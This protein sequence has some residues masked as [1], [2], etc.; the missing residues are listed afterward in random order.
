MNE[1]YV[2]EYPQAG[3][4]HIACPWGKHPHAISLGTLD[5]LGRKEGRFMLKDGGENA[6]FVI[7]SN[8]LEYL[9]ATKAWLAAKE[10]LKEGAV[11]RDRF[12]P[13][14]RHL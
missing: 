7:C 14:D 11:L 9:S 4:F 12:L 6:L 3:V 13:T 10:G 5:V 2:W 8:A 1:Y